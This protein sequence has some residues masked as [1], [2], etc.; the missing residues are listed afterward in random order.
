MSVSE[1]VLQMLQSA[2]LIPDLAFVKFNFSSHL[3]SK[4]SSPWIMY[5]DCCIICCSEFF[6]YHDFLHM[7]DSQLCGEGCA[8]VVRILV[9][10]MLT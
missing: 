9:V 4:G 1:L 2:Q 7:T 5:A 10:L 6:F 3:S 8:A